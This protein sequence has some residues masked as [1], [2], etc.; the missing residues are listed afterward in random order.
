MGR[1]LRLRIMQP[2]RHGRGQAAET[3]IH[4]PVIAVHLHAQ[5][6][7]GA[8]GQFAVLGGQQHARA[9]RLCIEAQRLQQCQQAAIEFE[10]VAATTVVEQL[11]L[12][13]VQVDRYCI[14]QQAAEGFERKQCV[15]ALLQQGQAR[16]RQR[17]R[18]IQ[19]QALQVAGTSSVVMRAPGGEGDLLCSPNRG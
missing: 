13:A 1:G 16:Q 5:Q 3:G 12:H 18:C 14:A 4:Q 2:Q 17:W 9:Q 7:V 15:V 6:Q 11:A 8:C 10:A 19:L